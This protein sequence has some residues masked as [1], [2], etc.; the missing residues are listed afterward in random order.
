MGR[1][2]VENYRIASQK[3]PKEFDGV[4]IAYLSDLHNVSYGRNNE[5]LKALLEREK[6]DYIFMGGDMIVGVRKFH[7][8]TAL[9]LCKSLTERYPVYMG[10]GNH[11]QKLRGYAETKDSLYPAYIKELEQ[12]GV[13]ILDNKSV[14]LERGAGAIR[15]YGLTPDY[16]YYAK[17]WKQVEMETAYM[18]EI[19][20]DCDKEHFCVLFA[21]TPKYFKTY[22]AW[23][24]DLVLSGHIHGG[25][26]ILPG[27]GGVIAPDYTLFPEYDYGYF[28]EKESQM[29]LSRGLG[30]H[31]IKLRIFNPPEV[32][33]VTLEQ[34]QLA[35]TDKNG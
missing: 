33:F 2:A 7:P 8:K 21:H 19:L 13:I 35:K 10:I 26:M 17:R 16:K 4:K 24:A 1:L 22:A 29:V 34:K 28:K 6:P 12:M 9:D 11:E 27:L 31:T 14:C 3:L 23:G 5:K 30:T 20:G 15:L 32:S 18:K 25:I